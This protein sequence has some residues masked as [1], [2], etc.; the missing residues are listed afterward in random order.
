[1]VIHSKCNFMNGPDNHSFVTD[2]ISYD[3]DRTKNIDNECKLELKT[4]MRWSKDCKVY[5][6]L[7][8]KYVTNSNSD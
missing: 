7:P 5:S 1:M 3:W 8:S 2:T 4:N 6:N